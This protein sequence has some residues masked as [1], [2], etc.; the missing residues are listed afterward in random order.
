MA[1]SSVGSCIGFLAD[2]LGVLLAVI[3]LFV[4][5]GVIA[6]IFD[7]DCWTSGDF[8]L[9]TGILKMPFGDVNFTDADSSD[10]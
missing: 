9:P 4:P 8:P 2:C 6:I 1:G 5:R 7:R 3:V 10:A